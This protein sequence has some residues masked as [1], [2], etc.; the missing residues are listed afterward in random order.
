MLLYASVWRLC[1][2]V[3]FHVSPVFVHLC[4]ASR[5]GCR[6][7]TATSSFPYFLVM[8]ELE[9]YI[10][11]EYLGPCGG[12]SWNFI[13]KPLDHSSA[14]SFCVFWPNLLK[15]KYSENQ[16]FI[17]MSSC[18]QVKTAQSNEPIKIWQ[19]RGPRST[20]SQENEFYNVLVFFFCFLNESRI[21][22]KHR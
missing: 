1:V 5:E 9:I 8:S 6:V 18:S 21:L 7:S 20:W 4:S 13:P 17:G 14:G 12:I 11:C 10:S 16:T 2:R 15:E 3:C 19:A 22:L